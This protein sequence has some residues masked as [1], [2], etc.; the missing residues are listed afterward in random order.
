MN[1]NYDNFDK[2]CLKCQQDQQNRIDEL[3]T[4]MMRGRSDQNSKLDLQ[5]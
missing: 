1:L 5:R 4:T 2:S 3:F